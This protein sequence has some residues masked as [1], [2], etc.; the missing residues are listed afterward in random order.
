MKKMP[1]WLEKAVFYQIYPQSFYDSNGDGIGDLPGITQKLAYIQSVGFNAIWLNPCFD[2]PFADAGYDVADYYRVA[3]RY[4][5]NDDLVDLFN[6]AHDRGM[7]VILDLVPGHT[8]LE[9]AW[10]K[11]SCKHERNEYTDWFIWTNSVWTPPLPN[12]Q[13]VR[14]YAERDGAYVVNFFYSQPALNYGFALPDPAYPWQQPTDAPGPQR[15]R[16]EIKNIMKYWIDLGADGFRVDMAASLVKNDPDK[17]ATSAVW[18]ELRAWLDDYAPEAM[19]VSEWG[20][21]LQALPAGFHADFTLGWTMPGFTSLF[22]KDRAHGRGADPYGA[23]YFDPS[24][25]GNI[26]EFVDEYLKHYLATRDLGFISLISGNHDVTPRLAK[27]RTMPDLIMPFIFLYTMPGIPFTY[28]GDEIGMTGVEGLPSKEGGYQRTQVRTPMQWNGG[29]NAG[30]STAPAEALYLPVEQAFKQVNVENQVSDPN[31]LLNAVRRLIQIR[32]AH[33][34][35]CASGGFEVV[36]AAFGDP[37]F[38]YKRMHGEEAILVAL[39]PAA[40][41]TETRLPEG[42]LKSIPAVLFGADGVFRQDGAGWKVQMPAQS[43]GIYQV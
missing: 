29:P 42:M 24:G 30:F 3:P 23:S 38:I 28:Y 27:G 11:A 13:N 6:A 37:L 39:N 5:T 18:Q 34:C 9:N 26:M 1:S 43:G 40:R 20:Y 17:R 14:G 19:L 8:S 15:V 36:H 12:L 2:S 4:G 22:R 35:L 32:L 25:R 21:P 7:H 41:P 31:S 10:F 16:Q 33:P